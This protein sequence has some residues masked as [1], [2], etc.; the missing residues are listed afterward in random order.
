M[1]IKEILVL[2][3]LLLLAGCATVFTP[4]HDPVTISALPVGSAVFMDGNRVGKTPVTIQVKR[5]LTP[6][7]VEVKSDGYHSQSIILQNQFN[8]V[9]LLNIFFWP[10]FIV[11][12]ATGTLMKAGQFNYEVELEAKDSVT[13]R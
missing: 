1:K 4:S 7:R 13:K 10:G 5:Q 2:S 8:G 3:P 11:D 9:S 6:P 12:A